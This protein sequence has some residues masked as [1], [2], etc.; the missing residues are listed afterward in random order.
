MRYA[1]MRAANADRTKK[2]NLRK[3]AKALLDKAAAQGIPPA[4]PPTPVTGERGDFQ[5]NVY[6]MHYG[7]VPSAR[8]T[9]RGNKRGL[10][11]TRPFRSRIQRLS[12]KRRTGGIK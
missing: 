4:T 3:N 2:G 5:G 11:G 8:E 9:R 6:A 12:R 1:D 7:S 10:G